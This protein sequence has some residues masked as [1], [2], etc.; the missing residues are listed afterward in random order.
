MLG[1][2]RSKLYIVGTHQVF[3]KK[4]ECAAIDILAN[5]EFNLVW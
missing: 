3:D 4:P 1:E 5:F 2:S